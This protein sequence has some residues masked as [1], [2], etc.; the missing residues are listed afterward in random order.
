MKTSIAYLDA[1]THT[2]S[3]TADPGEILSSSAPLG[4]QGVTVERGHN[5]LFL[6]D[7]AAVPGHYFA[8]LLSAPFSWEWKDGRKFRRHTMR[9]GEIWVNPAY[10]PFSHRITEYSE[11]AL[12]TLSTELAGELHRG[13]AGAP[14]PAPRMK[15]NS[16][17]AVLRRIILAL[18]AESEGRAPCSS[19]R[20][21]ELTVSLCAHFLAAYAREKTREW[22]APGLGRER[23]ARVMEYMDWRLTEEITLDDLAGA[24]GMSKW[25]FLRAFREAVGDTPHRHLM[26]RRVE[27]GLAL[28]RMGKWSISEV[29]NHLGFA[30]QSHFTRH[31]KRRFNATPAR[32][33]KSVSD[34]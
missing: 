18:L 11:F 24:A 31:F 13:L 25:H 10:T 7:N 21:A 1:G 19:L 4:W 12:V 28:L 30:D 22:R 2:P 3:A 34:L 15:H 27:K 16:D 9:T 17:D 6:P 20:A 32:Y 26:N 33:L 14:V 5:S 23:A 8:M 29:A